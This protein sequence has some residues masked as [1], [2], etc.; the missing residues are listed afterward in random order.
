MDDTC[1]GRSRLRIAC[2]F[3][4]SVRYLFI[5]PDWTGSPISTHF[6]RK[7]KLRK[8]A[9]IYDVRTEGGEGV[10]KSANFADKQYYKKCGQGGGGQKSQKKFRTSFMNGPLPFLSP[11]L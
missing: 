3:A 8:G 2:I 9:S 4:T 7:G 5:G 11:I 10:Q 1:Q 6:P